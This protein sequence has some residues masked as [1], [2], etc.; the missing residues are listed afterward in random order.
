MFTELALVMVGLFVTG[1][2]M[3]LGGFVNDG[4]GFLRFFAVLRQLVWGGAGGWEVVG[5]A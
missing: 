1:G 3:R 2:L 5:L 4:L